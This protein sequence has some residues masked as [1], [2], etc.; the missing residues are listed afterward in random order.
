MLSKNNNHNVDI[1]KG[2]SITMQKIHKHTHTHTH[3]HTH[4]H[5]HT[6]TLT[7]T[8]THSHTHT[9]TPHAASYYLSSNSGALSI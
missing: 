7:L 2:S 3:A 9:H 4:T 6:H 8:H 1:K 5:T